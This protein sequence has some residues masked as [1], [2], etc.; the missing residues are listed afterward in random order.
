MS[1]YRHGVLIHNFNEDQFGLDLQRRVPAEGAPKKSMSHLAHGWKER[2]QVSEEPAAARSYVQRHLLFGHSGDMH[3]PHT[4]L[5]KTEFA[6]AHNYFMQDPAKVESGL[7][8]GM[9]KISAE[10]Y[11]SSGEPLRVAAELA[12]STRHLGAKLRANW[13]NGSQAHALPSSERFTTSQKAATDAMLTE[14]PTVP[15]V[16]RI[17]PKV[18][19]FS[20]TWERVRLTRGGCR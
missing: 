18:R 15:P 3:D 9:P 16:E 6:T 2:L 7:E 20:S 13:G 11:Q 14:A 12:L 8:E 10:G 5:Q 1:S 19:E 4:N 17:T